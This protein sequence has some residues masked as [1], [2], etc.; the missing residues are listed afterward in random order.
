M[1]TSTNASS[2]T[3]SGTSGPTRAGSGACSVRF[4]DS[5]RPITVYTFE[6]EF[7]GPD[8]NAMFRQSEAILRRGRHALVMDM[9]RLGGMSALLRHQVAEWNVA[10]AVALGERRAGLA[11]VITD[12]RERGIITAIYWHNPPPYPYLIC[13]SVAEALAWCNQKLAP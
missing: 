9:R 2:A 6:G 13:E 7:T 12:S 11:M 4:D 1:S 8:L 10:N 3:T 5:R